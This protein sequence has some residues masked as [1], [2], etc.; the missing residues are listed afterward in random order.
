MVTLKLLGRLSL[1]D[2][3]GPVTG[4][5]TRRLLAAGKTDEAL[6]VLLSPADSKPGPQLRYLRGQVL[7]ALHRPM[8]ALAWYDASA[9]DYGAEWYAAAVARAHQRL[10][11][12]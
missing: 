10:D 7:E 5:I 6:A 2:S 11:R 12:H 4:Q 3:N 1:S 8:E 9:Q